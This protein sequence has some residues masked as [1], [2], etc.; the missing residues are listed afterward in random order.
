MKKIIFINACKTKTNK[1][2]LAKEMYVGQFSEKAYR[3]ATMIEHDKIFFL[4]TV[5]H[6]VDPDQAVSKVN[7]EFRDMSVF[8]KREWAKITL[9]QIIEK[10]IDIEKDELIFLTSK[11]YWEGMVSIL[12]KEGKSTKNFRTP[13]FG[14]AQGEQIGWITD[15]LKG[16]NEI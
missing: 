15:K 6:V 2:G 9:N 14:L 16:L 1:N 7:K 4:S 5:F 13:L 8:E 10:G 12:H 11:G 3:Y